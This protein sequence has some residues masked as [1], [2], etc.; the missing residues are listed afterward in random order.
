M[1]NVQQSTSD[2]E[3][4]LTQTNHVMGNGKMVSEVLCAFMFDRGYVCN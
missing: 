3:Y 2:H 4:V 1:L